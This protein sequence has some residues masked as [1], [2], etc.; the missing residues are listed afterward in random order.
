MKT[1]H[2]YRIEVLKLDNSY[3]VHCFDD[4]A[5]IICFGTC[6][7]ECLISMIDEWLDF[8]PSGV[9]YSYFLKGESEFLDESIKEGCADEE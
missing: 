5:F 8:G 3:H 7:S 4:D 1:E 2:K 9:N 6:S